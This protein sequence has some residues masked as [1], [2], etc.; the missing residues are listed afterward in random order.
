M[1][2]PALREKLLASSARITGQAQH[3]PREKI[4]SLWT[5]LWHFDERAATLPE[6]RAAAV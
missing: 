2:W 5:A 1:D 6:P 3:I 4:Q